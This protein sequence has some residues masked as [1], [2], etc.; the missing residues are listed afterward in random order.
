MWQLYALG[1]LFASSGESVFDKVAI[2][3]DRSVD[4]LI[5]TFWRLV[6][7][8]LFTLVIG[9]FGWLGGIQFSFNWL[10]VLVAATGIGNSLI[11]T[12]LLRR[13][14][15]TGIGAIAY[16]SPFVFLI[17]D[18]RLLHTTFTGG[19]IAGI[20][21][22]V[23]GGFAF[24]VDG[25][26]HPFKREYSPLVWLMLL[27]M[28]AYSGIESYAFKYLH[29]V[30]G[31]TAVGFTVSYGVLMVVGLLA[32]V[33]FLGKQ[34]LLW[35][36]AAQLYIP[37]VSISKAFDAASSVLWVQALTLAAVSQVSAMQALEPIVLFALTMLVQD[38]LR[39]RT[40]EKLGRSRLHWKAAA[41]SM[42]V[43]GGL[44]VN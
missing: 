43:I 4:S 7:F 18:T 22:M 9:W 29:G 32:L 6:L 20:I 40:G 19:E 11:Y 33:L 24:A 25:R 23:L 37:R 1:S 13:V 2:V 12:Y 41:I 21:L 10:I 8:F 42:L 5:A 44:L 34:H 36:R 31:I 26:T 39:L 30:S 16:L 38:V 35:K 17:I 3:S 27:Y 14:E 28:V 15:I